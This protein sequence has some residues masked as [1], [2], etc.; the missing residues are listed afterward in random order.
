M[1]EEPLLK[2]PLL[3]SRED[4]LLLMLPLLLSRVL[5]RSIDLERSIL[6]ERS[7]VLEERSSIPLLSIL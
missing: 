1:E 7:I 3:L 2:L 6:L 4:E 5:A